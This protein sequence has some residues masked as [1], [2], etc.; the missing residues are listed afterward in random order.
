MYLYTIVVIN[1]S[2]SYF[3][4]MQKYDDYKDKITEGA[5]I[6][7]K[8]DDILSVSLGLGE[9]G[10]TLLEKLER[11]GAK[12]FFTSSGDERSLSHD[13]ALKSKFTFPS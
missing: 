9:I 8:K 5:N 2:L 4:P 7:L 6:L 13:D 10:A 3:V 1:Y 11:S 12:Y